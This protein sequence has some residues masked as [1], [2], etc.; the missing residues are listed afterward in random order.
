MKKLTR[1]D[2]EEALNK[3]IG[4]ATTYGA[5]T[6]RLPWIDERCKIAANCSGSQ[7]NR[8]MEM[9]DAALA[10]VAA[11]TEMLREVEWAASDLYENP[12]C[13][14]CGGDKDEEHWD[15]CALA[16]LLKDPA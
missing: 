4:C 8:C 15:D 13:P 5:L 16:A 9:F 3:A 12:I 2:F 11:L 10:R 14:I 7:H 1:D 6:E